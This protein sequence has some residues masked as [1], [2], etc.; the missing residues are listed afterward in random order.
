[1]KKLLF[2]PLLFVSFVLSAMPIGEKRARELAVQ[3]FAKTATRATDVKLDLEWAGHDIK[4]P[5]TRGSVVD[6]DEAL[7]YIYNRADSE[8]FVI[9]SGDDSQRPVVA[10]S[11]EGSVNVN[12]MADATRWLLSAWCEQ[13]EAAQEANVPPLNGNIIFDDNGEDID[14]LLY[15]T[16][17][18][19]QGEP[20]NRLSPVYRAGQAPSGCVATA[21]SIVMRYYMWPDCGVGTTKAYTL[22]WH[23]SDVDPSLHQKINI[24][25]NELGHKYDWNKMPLRYDR[26]QYSVAQGDEVAKLM[27]DVGTVMEMGWA[28]GGSGAVTGYCASRLPQYFKYGKGAVWIGDGMYSR[29]EWFALLRE[30][31][32]IYGP[33]IGAGGGHAYVLDG[34][35]SKGYFHMNYG[36][37]GSS[38]GYY[39]LPDNDF[40]RSMGACFY[41]EPDR[42]GTSK[43]RDRFG[44]AALGGGDP[45]YCTVFGLESHTKDIVPNK[46]IE[47]HRAIYRSD[48]NGPFT[49][50]FNLVLCDREGNFIETIDENYFENL[51]PGVDIRDKIASKVVVKREFKEGYRLRYYFKGENPGVWEWL[52]ASNGCDEIVLCASPEEIAE[53]TE[54][55]YD[56]ST[57][58]LNLWSLI[59]LTYEV[60]D[61]NGKVSSSGSVYGGRHYNSR[62]GPN[63][64]YIKVGAEL[65]F[66][67]YEP[68]EYTVSLSCGGGR[69]YNLTI[70][71]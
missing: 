15:E 35:D 62:K 25:A 29:E 46:E 43:P 6:A 54:F 3:F 5:V 22:D 58:V 59:P 17:K 69:P 71:I 18:W 67:N 14:E 39:Y 16:A 44:M 40:T 10:Y 66:K 61:A 31:L 68:G 32:Q 37:G 63:S 34:Y 13:I 33:M 1:M 50:Y 27:Y 12:D 42:T 45:W 30:N 53:R 19:N 4:Q 57:K 7:L 8:G 60:K 38:D 65:S 11:H 26:G 48:S 41:L 21:M 23:P 2:I 51:A 20:Y 70:V 56:K 9:I 28:P 47:L 49:G 24:P 64:E 55:I 36:W 52:R